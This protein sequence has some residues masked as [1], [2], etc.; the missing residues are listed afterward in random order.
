MDLEPAEPSTRLIAL[1]RLRP[2]DLMLRR[3]RGHLFGW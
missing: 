1:S 3:T 2:L